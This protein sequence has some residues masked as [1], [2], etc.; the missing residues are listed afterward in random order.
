MQLMYPLNWVRYLKL[1]LNDPIISNAMIANYFMFCQW[2]TCFMHQIRNHQFYACH[3]SYFGP[4]QFD[5]FSGPDSST[6]CS[7]S[8]FSYHLLSICF[9]IKFVIFID[10]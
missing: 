10:P 8:E 9:I 2:P 1:N 7:L 4:S 6:I 5:C 3:F